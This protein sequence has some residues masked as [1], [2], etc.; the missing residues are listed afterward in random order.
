[1][2]KPDNK[3]FSPRIHDSP[4]G[5]APN[6]HERMESFA[7]SHRRLRGG[8][9]LLLSTIFLI[10]ILVLSAFFIYKTNSI[11]RERAELRLAA[12]VESRKNVLDLS[13]RETLVDL[14]SLVNRDHFFELSPES[15]ERE[16][17]DL[18]ASRDFFA[19]M[20]FINAD[21]IQ[22]AYAGPAP[23]LRH[24]D[25]SDAAWY[26][27]LIHQEKPYIVTDLLLEEHQPHFVIA[28]KGIV[29]GRTVVVRAT[30]Y[31]DKL[32]DMVQADPEGERVRG[33]LVNR[34]GWILAGDAD[35]GES[36]Q[37]APY[38]PPQEKEADVVL[39]EWEGDSMLTGHGW[40]ETLPWSVV[41]LQPEG[42][43]FQEAH[44]LRNTVIIVSLL[45]FG[46]GMLVVWFIVNRLFTAF[47]AL[48]QEMGELKGQL[49]HAHKMISVGQLAGEVAHEINNPLAIIDSE[50]GVIQDMLDP[51]MGLD[52]SPEA[53]RKELDEINKAVKR[54]KGITRK[55]LSFVRKTEMRRVESDVN[56]LLDDMVSGMKEQE[57]RVSGI[58]L[59]KEY[60][61]DLPR[62]YVD[63]DLLQ[64][65]FLN[66]VNN[67]GDA[68]EK[69]DTITLATATEGNWVAVTVSDTGK[70]MTS[71]QV[72]KI[73]M[74][75][76]TT[77]EAGKGTGL[78]L[79]IC[80][81]IIESFGGRL[82]VQSAP[83][84]GSSFK[85]LLP[86]S[87]R[88]PDDNGRAVVSSKA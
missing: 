32:V 56:H 85:V 77:K 48:D 80:L 6:A 40:L 3:E 12:L 63:P 45:L 51:Q 39:M 49:Y 9:F 31:P 5:S 88:S 83:G 73:F 86:L 36:L 50:T 54:A 17:L 41:M 59:V 37:P 28:L 52:S 35:L 8:T 34:H 76:F 69:G 20:G 2:P 30:L 24:K 19:G 78:G 10:S 60:A 22:T 4:S 29:E 44:A 13:M 43:A 26:R 68:V 16:F 87:D 23:Q 61:E 58:N 55:L 7:T 18:I 70:G 79:P 64:Q 53:I 33:F 72:E 62:L 47:R 11:L 42:V 14:F 46:V 75:F 71:D 67:A 65:V 57:F 82:E 81:N 66:L 15:M 1:M 74:P 21:G 27:D 38:V 84:A 25:Y